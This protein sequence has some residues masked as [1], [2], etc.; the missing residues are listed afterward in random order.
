[1]SINTCPGSYAGINAIAATQTVTSQSTALYTQAE[2]P[3]YDA[4]LLAF[5]VL[6]F[7]RAR[8]KRE[9][10]TEWMLLRLTTI[11][12]FLP[13]LHPTCVLLTELFTKAHHNS[14]SLCA[15]GAP[16]GDQRSS[17]YKAIVKEICK[18]LCI[19]MSLA[20]KVDNSAVHLV[21]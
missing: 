9:I 12:L 8:S 4:S 19:Q 14:C 18:I 17:S 10:Y 5:V 21:M 13:S 1:M 7:V 6:D 16:G 20:H 3:L 2:P 11:L 15:S